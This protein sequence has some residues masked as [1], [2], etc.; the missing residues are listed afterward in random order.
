MDLNSWLL[1]ALGAGAVLVYVY[2]NFDPLG[3]KKVVEPLLDKYPVLRDL[4]AK[5]E[6]DADGY[7]ADKLKEIA[8]KPKL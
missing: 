1:L 3:L 6:A 8:R 5:L 4:A 2:H 7:V